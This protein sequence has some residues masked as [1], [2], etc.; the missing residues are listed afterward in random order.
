MNPSQTISNEYLLT[1]RHIVKPVVEILKVV[2]ECGGKARASDIIKRLQGWNSSSIYTNLLIAMAQ[3][4]IAKEGKHYILTDKGKEF[5]KNTVE[6]LKQFIEAVEK[7][8]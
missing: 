7:I 2:A 5:L 3:G 1:P 6:F 8:D 4:L